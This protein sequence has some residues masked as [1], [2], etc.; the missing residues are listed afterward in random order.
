M[1]IL[2]DKSF[3][4]GAINI[5]SVSIYSIV[6]YPYELLTDS[7][8]TPMVYFI[9]IAPILSIIGIKVSLNKLSLTN[10][11]GYILNLIL[12]SI[13]ILIC[14]GIVILFLLVES[15]FYIFHGIFDL[16]PFSITR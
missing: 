6:L 14:W 2:F 16:I 5:I 7:V 12:N 11:K 4:F 3:I 8:Y 9:F 10:N 15:K 13:Y 1:K